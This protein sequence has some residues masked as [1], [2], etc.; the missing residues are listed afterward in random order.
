MRAM[1]DRMVIA[2]PFVLS[3]A[4]ADELIYKVLTTLDM[5]YARWRKTGLAA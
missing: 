5:A 1:G 2:P 3:H 4:G